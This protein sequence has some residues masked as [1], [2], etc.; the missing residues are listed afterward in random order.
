MATKREAIEEYVKKNPNADPKEVVE[1]LGSSVSLPYVYNVVREMEEAGETTGEK[2]PSEYEQGY[3][4]AIRDAAAIVLNDTPHLD[5]S[6]QLYLVN[7]FV[8][9]EA[10]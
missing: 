7:L 8:D 6:T 1:G 5:S 10:S 9:L 3:Y 4:T 2:G